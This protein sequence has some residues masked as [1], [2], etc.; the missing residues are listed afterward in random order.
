MSEDPKKEAVEDE[1]LEEAS[2]GRLLGEADGN[3]WGASPE[4]PAAE[5]DGNSWG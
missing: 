5:H 4:A 3:S 2:G 1:A